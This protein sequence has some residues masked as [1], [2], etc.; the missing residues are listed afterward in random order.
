M[1]YVGDAY[2]TIR[3]SLFNLVTGLGTAKDPRTLFDGVPL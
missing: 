1:S 2:A 3:D